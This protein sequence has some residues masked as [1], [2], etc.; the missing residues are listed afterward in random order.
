MGKKGQKKNTTEE[1]ADERSSS[2]AAWLLPVNIYGV[3]MGPVPGSG[4]CL[5]NLYL[6]TRRETETLYYY[7]SHAGPCHNTHTG[8]TAEPRRHRGSAPI[9]SRGRRTGTR[10]PAGG[11][12]GCGG[13]G[14]GLSVEPV[15][16]GKSLL[17]SWGGCLPL[18]QL[19]DVL[20]VFIQIVS[21]NYSSLTFTK[22]LK[23]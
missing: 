13:P 3:V 1:P 5:N 12:R 8:Q 18:E 23:D 2:G 19:S 7:G 9:N 20:E 21:I 15:K 11:E 6:S 22:R 16:R 17:K 10:T 14:P 4:Y